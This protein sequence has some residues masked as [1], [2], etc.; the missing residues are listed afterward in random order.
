VVMGAVLHCILVDILT[1]ILQG[2]SSLDWA[3][4]RSSHGRGGKESRA[5][6]WGKWNCVRVVTETQSHAEMELR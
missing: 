1:G 5:G 4:G 2:S 3:S 6:H